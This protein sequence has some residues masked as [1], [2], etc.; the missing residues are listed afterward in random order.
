MSKKDIYA[1][2][3]VPDYSKDVEE[4]YKDVNAEMARQERAAKRNQNIAI[5][6][7]MARIFADASHMKDG[8]MVKEQQSLAAP[9]NERL[10]KIKSGKA[11][12]KQQYAKDRAAARKQQ[13]ATDLSL[14]SARAKAASDALAN[15]LAVNK[16]LL[17]QQNKDRDFEL[18]VK[19]AN[20]TA[21]HNKKMRDIYQQ[22]IGARG[23]KSEVYIIDENGDK[24]YFDASEYAD[25]LTE[26][27]L[28][29]IAQDPSLVPKRTE[30]EGWNRTPVQVE[31]KYPSSQTKEITVARYNEKQRKAQ[32]QAAD[33]TKSDNKTMPGVGA[34]SNKMP[35]VK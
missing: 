9:A 30:Y 16:M 26:A 34:K 2:L 7:D 13:F 27:Y 24:R 14:A 21:A 28:E 8:W 20:E 17:D 23:N 1:G 35:G 5:L 4:E 19:K 32:A 18:A 22:R 33:E 29:A 6:G 15:E 3:Q 25:P 10:E 11:A 12:M 31:D